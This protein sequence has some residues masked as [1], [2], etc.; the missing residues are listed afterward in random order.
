MSKVRHLAKARTSSSTF[1]DAV[2]EVLGQ[3]SEPI[4]DDLE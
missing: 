3:V 4:F 2:Q 1:V